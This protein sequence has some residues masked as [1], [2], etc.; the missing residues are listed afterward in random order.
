M[1]ER[2]AAV[3][4]VVLHLA[5]GVFPYAASGLVTPVWGYVV[6]YAVWLALAFV[7]IR[8]LGGPNR[9]PIVAPAIPLA[10]LAFWF[11]F[12]TAGEVLLDWTA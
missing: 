1:G 12:V 7:L 5:V 2:V 3:V 4:G 11:A 9:R 8:L 10:A 6:L